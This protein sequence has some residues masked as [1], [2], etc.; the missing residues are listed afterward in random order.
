MNDDELLLLLLRPL[1]FQSL[2][3]FFS[4]VHQ[5][6]QEKRQRRRQRYVK[7]RL[8]GDWGSCEGK[9]KSIAGNGSI[10]ITQ[11]KKPPEGWKPV[12]Q[13]PGR[14][15]DT[16]KKPKQRS[17][18]PQSTQKEKKNES[19]VAYGPGGYSKRAQHSVLSSSFGFHL[20]SPSMDP[21][22]GSK[23]ASSSFVDT[24]YTTFHP[25]QSRISS[26]L[27]EWQHSQSPPFLSKQT[28]TNSSSLRCIAPTI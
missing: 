10:Q 23:E 17:S 3:S 22:G 27:I 18:P 14:Q 24:I 11:K 25:S 2:F 4:F 21:V 7:H 28:Q 26:S 12:H 8:V 5:S 20:E 1:E 16:A 6:K 13:A 9:G 15:E 19:L